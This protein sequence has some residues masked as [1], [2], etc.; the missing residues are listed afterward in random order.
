MSWAPFD[1]QV[2]TTTVGVFIK[3]RMRPLAKVRK[4]KEKQFGLDIVKNS[5]VVLAKVLLAQFILY[6]LG[7]GFCHLLFKQPLITYEPS[8]MNHYEYGN[9]SK[10]VPGLSHPLE[11]HPDC[12]HVVNASC[13]KVLLE[14]EW[15]TKPRSEQQSSKSLNIALIIL[16]G[17]QNF[18]KRQQTRR[19]IEE[20]KNR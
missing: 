17:T 14:P 18:V 3:N 15:L 8:F 7:V 10:L 6:H 11:Q 9:F 20:F 2:S 16:S 12:I 19:L 13:I 4:T 1:C 5:L